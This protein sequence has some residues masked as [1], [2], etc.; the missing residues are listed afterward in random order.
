MSPIS[1]QVFAGER[2]PAAD[3]TTATMETRYPPTPGKNFYYIRCM[4]HIIVI[5]AFVG[6]AVVCHMI[7]TKNT[8]Y[9]E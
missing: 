2:R 7:G 6:V 3:L 1:F 5:V 4:L 9:R 8:I